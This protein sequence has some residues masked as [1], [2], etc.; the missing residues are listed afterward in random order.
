[1]RHGCYQK[2]E[3][4]YINS[5]NYSTS[6]AQQGQRNQIKIMLTSWKPTSSLHGKHFYTLMKFLQLLIESFNLLLLLFKPL[7]ELRII[8]ISSPH[9]RKFATVHNYNIDEF[10]ISFNSY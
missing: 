6:I 9:S 8:L 4:V 2:E 1:M 3:T 7:E 10:K 5:N